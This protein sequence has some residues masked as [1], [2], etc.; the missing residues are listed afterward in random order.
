MILERNILKLIC[1]LLL[2]AIS[3]SCDPEEEKVEKI[4]NITLSVNKNDLVANGKDAITFSVTANEKDI[5]NRVKIIYKEEN[6]LLSG[7]TFSTKESGT[8][9]FYATFEDLLSSEIQI[10]AMPVA[11]TLKADTTSIKANNKNVVTF[12]AT[13]DDENVTADIEIFLINEDSETLIIGNN[14][15]TDQEGFYEFY[16]K[17]DDLTSNKITIAAVPFIL[18]LKADTTLIKTIGTDSVKFTVT[19]DDYDITDEAA[20][21]RKDRENSILL[22][23]NT[24]GTAEEG[25]Y[26]FFAQYQ[27]QTSNSVSIEAVI[28]ILTLTPNKTAIVTGERVTFTTIS[29]EVNNVSPEA[30]LHIICNNSEETIKG[31]VFTP[32][33]FGVYS[34]YATYKGSISDTVDIKVTPA[35]VTIST[36]NTLLKSTGADFATFTVHADGYEINNADI[37]LKGGA[38]DTKLRENRFSSNLQGTFSFYA[39][40]D[41]VKSRHTEVTVR[42]VNFIKQ[43]CAMAVVATWCGFSPQM[44]D[45][46]HDI[47]N[48]YSNEIQIISLHRSS[49]SLASTDLN[50]DYFMNKGELT[51]TPTGFID[52]DRMLHSRT[53]ESIRTSAQQMR[54]MHPVSSGVAVVSQVD[55]KNINVTLKVKANQT[56][57]YSVCAI[58]VEDNVMMQQVIYLNNSK[59]NSIRNDGYIH[60]SVATYLMPN[61]NMYTG[62]PLGIIQSGSE[63]TE[64]FSI[65]LDKIVTKQR[66]INHSNCRV[67]AYVMKKEG[68]SYYINNV[69]TCPINGSVDYFYVE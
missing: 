23:G 12:S 17:Y 51:A 42:F 24:F 45:V 7:N 55:D 34:I 10:N 3:T 50:V 5:T 19:E 6:T 37:Y 67:V 65:P 32:S 56:E 2:A 39:Q 68:D 1:L 35:S 25:V 46:F 49:S 38:Q 14:F 36:D 44:T 59:E 26:E 20:I 30:F 21:Y 64:S 9:T 27:K 53:V 48:R 62:K 60:H 47:R 41:G 33:K 57:E 28:P 29:D 63:V 43:S 54:Y 18:T 22:E 4:Q 58:I 52:L 13:A 61:T 11:L 16:C 15:K 69:T 66:T 40:Y 8:Y 31:N